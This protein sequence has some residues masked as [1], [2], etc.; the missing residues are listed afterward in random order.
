M[1]SGKAQQFVAFRKYNCATFVWIWIS[2]GPLYHVSNPLAVR[3]QEEDF[4]LLTHTIFLAF[5][6]FDSFHWVN[7]NWSTLWIWF[8]SVIDEL[9]REVPLQP[10]ELVITSNE[11]D[12]LKHFKVLHPPNHFEM[13]STIWEHVLRLELF[14]FWKQMNQLDSLESYI[15]KLMRHPSQ[16]IHLLLQIHGKCLF[17]PEVFICFS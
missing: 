1:F 17:F 15:P 10:T 13:F 14:L 6:D 11:P 16:T 4:S 9:I 7:E 2:I 8:N 3:I 12:Q 5:C